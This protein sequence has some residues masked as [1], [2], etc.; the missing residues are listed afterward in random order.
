MSLIIN[1]RLLANRKILEHLAIL[2]EENTT[3]RFG[4]LLW[5]FDVCGRDSEGY[6]HDN[7]HDESTETLAR[8]IDADKRLLYEN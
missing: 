1:S 3:L 5:T 8:I 2:V 4:Q 7:Y 6:L